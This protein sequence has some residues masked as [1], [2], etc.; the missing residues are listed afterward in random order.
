MTEF[1]GYALMTTLLEKHTNIEHSHRFDEDKLEWIPI[2]KTMKPQ[3]STQKG[4]KPG[5]EQAP[6]DSSPPA[7][8]A[9]G[10]NV[11]KPPEAQN[12]PATTD[13]TTV[14]GQPVKSDGGAMP[15]PGGADPKAPAVQKAAAD[16]VFTAEEKRAGAVKKEE[17]KKAE[18]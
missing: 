5:F 17:K 11:S 13:T 12:S 3:Q 4:R 15:E 9:N 18:E 10:Q 14:A 1:E 16:K 6:A 2:P 8:P 7:Q